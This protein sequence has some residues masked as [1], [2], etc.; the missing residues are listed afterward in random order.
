MSHER[1]AQHCSS[2]HGGEE[3][4]CKGHTTPNLKQRRNARLL[5]A[6][7]GAPVPDVDAMSFSELDQWI[8]RHWREW[9]ALPA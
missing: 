7:T 6:L 8:A 4:A 2:V 5:S 3:A 9:M 1:A